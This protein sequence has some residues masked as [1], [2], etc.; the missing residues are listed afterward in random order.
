MYARTGADGKSGLK[1]GLLSAAPLVHLRIPCYTSAVNAFSYITQFIFILSFGVLFLSCSG[2]QGPDTAAFDK[3]TLRTLS[4]EKENQTLWT[5]ELEETR[6]LQ[7][8]SALPDVS[9]DIR[10]E[11]RIVAAVELSGSPV[12]PFLQGFG[13]LDTAGISKELAAFLAAFCTSIS[14]WNFRLEDFA[15]SAIF[16]AVL[17][18]NDVEKSWNTVFGKDFPIRQEGSTDT[19]KGDSETAQGD[20]PRAPIPESD[21]FSSYIYGAPFAEEGG[22][23][24]PVRFYAK[25]GIL[26]AALFIAMIADSTETAPSFKITQI[27]IIKMDTENIGS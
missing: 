3:E 11:P 24:V 19:H 21:I 20:N 4:L 17:F 8:F 12:Y 13:S 16:S 14:T 22:V 18:K 6:L 27:Q 26:D 23:L 25:N 10:L 15:E 5:R 1:N 2:S 7:D 9:P